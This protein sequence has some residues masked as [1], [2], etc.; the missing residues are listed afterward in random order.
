M[1]S[2]GSSPALSANYGFT[3]AYKN[4]ANVC[5]PLIRHGLTT[6]G[7]QSGTLGLTDPDSEGTTL[8]AKI[9][10]Q[11][12]GV[13]QAGFEWGRDRGY[14]VTGNSDPNGDTVHAEEYMIAALDEI[15]PLLERERIID[16]EQTAVLTMKITKT[17]CP[18]CKDQLIAFVNRHNVRLRIKA[19]QLWKRRSGG[20]TEALLAVHEL[21]EAGIHML[22][23]DVE[24]KAGKVRKEIHGFG[25]HELGGIQID[26]V[27]KDKMLR[28][29]EEYNSL[30]EALGIDTEQRYKEMKAAY[31]GAP[32]KVNEEEL[33]RKAVTL[34]N[35]ALLKT[36]DKL[37]K[38]QSRMNTMEDV[39]EHES[40]ARRSSRASVKSATMQSFGNFQAEHEKKSNIVNRL[41]ANKEKHQQVIEKYRDKDKL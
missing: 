27:S 13:F 39:I 25:Q 29:R 1:S 28:L 26:M 34:H 5:E 18:G 8:I 16:A 15:W 33:R 11:L 9:N 30:C 19:A 20:A 22:P 31:K 37:D 12:V 35:D 6:M 41:N 4:R 38:L 36:Q 17:P 2:I 21:A 10:H 32:L 23:W 24:S 3:A 14:K 7:G 40:T